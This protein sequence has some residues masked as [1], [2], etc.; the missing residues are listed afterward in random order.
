MTSAIEEENL[1]YINVDSSIFFV[2]PTSDFYLNDEQYNI[3][4][5]SNIVRF[6]VTD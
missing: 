4:A 5:V 3:I 6:G 1:A 2:K